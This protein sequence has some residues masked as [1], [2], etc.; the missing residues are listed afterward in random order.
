[1]PNADPTAATA[2]TQAQIRALI[3]HSG[4]MCLLERVLRWDADAIDCL[5]LSHRDADNPL[6]RD[7][8]LP[9]AAGIEYGAQAMAVHGGLAEPG[10]VPRRGYLAILTGVE[11]SVARLDDC[12]EPLRIRA[13]RRAAIATGTQYA[14][15]VYA[16]ERLLLAGEAVIALA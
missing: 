14:F 7:G 12:A 16:G 9:V 2:L 1:M 13:E 15:A 6:R 5:A 3:P 8:L 11:W 10:P 4:A